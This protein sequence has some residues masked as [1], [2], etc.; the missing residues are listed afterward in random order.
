MKTTIMKKLGMLSLST[1]L[2]FSMA[3]CT[4]GSNGESLS[5]KDNGGNVQDTQKENTQSD[6]AKEKKDPVKITFWYRNGVGEQEYTDQVE[7]KLNELLAEDEVYNYV[8]VDL[9]P[10][11]A[12][13]ATDFSLAQASREQIDLVSNSGLSFLAEA[14]NGSFMPLDDLLTQFP[15]ATEELPDWLMEMQKVDGIT[16]GIPNYQQAANEYFL[17]TPKEYLDHSGYTEEQ[18]HEVFADPD[19]RPEDIAKFCENYIL[20]IREYTGKDTKWITFKALTDTEIWTNLSNSDVTGTGSYVWDMEEDEW[21]CMET[22]EL[23]KEAFQYAADFYEKGYIHPDIATVGNGPFQAKNFLNDE[24][25]VFA[26]ATSVGTPEYVSAQYTKSYGLETVAIPVADYCFLSP[27]WAAGGVS[28]SSTC[29]HPE[30]TMAVLTMLENAKY[31]EFYNT[32]VYGLENI[33]YT[34]NEDGTITTLEYDG[35]QGNAECS[36]TCWKH[37][38]GNTFNAWINQSG[39]EEVRDY[40]LE[41][42]NSG[43]K[44]VYSPVLGCSFKTAGVEN[45]LSQIQSVKSEYRNTLIQGIKGKDWENYYNEYMSRLKTAG[46]ENVLEELNRQAEEFLQN[47]Q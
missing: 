5:G 13:Y 11:G 42:I 45:Q 7:Q 3:G 18:I 38:V 19:K 47:K 25:Y 15:E 16:Y 6:A 26:F 37:A 4:N 46:I 27:V 24:S 39:S 14:E 31:S 32:L 9:K 33:H 30:E 43:K 10:C 17:V 20:A 22:S 1:V 2:A 36:Y 21:M 28:V 12:N 8:T 41:E 44:L 40:I 34:K 29:E 23:M 35:S